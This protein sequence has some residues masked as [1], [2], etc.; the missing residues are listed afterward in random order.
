MRI[1]LTGNLF[2]GYEYDFYEALTEMGHGV[3]LL[4]N[5]IHGPFHPRHLRSVPEWIM[6]ALLPYKLKFSYFTDR[7]VRM[8][9]E[10]LQQLIEQRGYD[11][12]LVIG[13]KTIVPEVLQ[14]FPGRKILW[15][16]DSLTRYEEVLRKVPHFDDIFLF[17]PTD[18]A[19]VKSRFD[20]HS[21][22]LATGFSP[23]MYRKIDTQKRFDFSFVGSYYEK[24]EFYLG[25]LEK[26]SG[27]LAIYGDF[28]RANSP[29][30][31][32][33]VKHYHIDRKKTSPLYNR[34]RINI[35]IHHDQSREGLSPRTFEILGSGGFE[36]VER[37]KVALEFFKEDEDICFYEGREEF[38]KKPPFT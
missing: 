3:D 35:N 19:V 1:L 12:L 5:N 2:H 30:V 4:F 31:R 22:F 6:Y 23:T 36:L 17:E 28:F 14:S 18:V 34:S 10:R 16:L 38:W 9:N 25:D 20:K 7:S 11:L 33:K 32:S 24:R 27:N 13:G 8:Y 21:R 15:F 26:L 29:F 37:Q